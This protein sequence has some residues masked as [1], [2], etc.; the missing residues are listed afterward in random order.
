MK[1]LEKEKIQYVQLKEDYEEKLAQFEKNCSTLLQEA[2]VWNLRLAVKIF[3]LIFKANIC[4]I[5]ESKRIL[6]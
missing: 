2:E 1:E 6:T 3:N 5:F 4:T